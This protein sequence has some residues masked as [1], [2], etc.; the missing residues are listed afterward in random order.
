[1]P[2]YNF[3]EYSNNFFM[4]SGSLWNYYRDEVNNSAN[5]NVNN[6]INNNKTTTRK[7][8]EYKTKVIGSTPKNNN[9]IDAKV[10]V[11]LKH[12]SNSWR[13]LDLPLIKCEIEL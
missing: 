9:M 10:V 7:S 1:M 5:N 4:T 11:P 6:N 8:I 3:L 12:L 2:M 13:S